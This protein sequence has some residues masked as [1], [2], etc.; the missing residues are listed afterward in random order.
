MTGPHQSIICF[1]M[2]TGHGAAA[3]TT[4]C[5]L[6]VSY[7][8]RTSSGS[9]SIRTNIAGTNWPLVTRYFWMASRADSGSNLDM[10]TVV[11]PMACALIVH[12]H[13]AV[14]YSGAGLR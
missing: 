4:R 7:E 1:L 6:D 9:F 3:C 13:G 10:I 5:R 14:W 12:K 2:S 11:T 8:L